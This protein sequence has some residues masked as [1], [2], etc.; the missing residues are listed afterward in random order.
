MIIS[1]SRRTDIPAFYSE[2][3][4]NRIKAGY[5]TVPN[6]FNRNQISKVSLLPKDIDVIVFWTRNPR[7]LLSYLTELDERG[8]RYYFQ[9][10][11]MAN[12][13]SLDIKSPHVD[14]AIDTFIQLSETIGPE[15]VIW[16]YDPI[17]FTTATSVDFHLR[18]YSKIASSLSEHTRRSV[19]S[20]VDEYPKAKR[21]ISAMANQSAKYIPIEQVPKCEFE[22]FIK[23]LV[24]ISQENK[25]EIFSCAEEIDL[26][27]LGV[28]P[29]KCIDDNYINSV[30]GIDVI[31]KKDPSQR[32]VCGCV[33]SKDIGA[34]DT[35]LFGCQY[36]YATSSFERAKRQHAEHNPLSPSIIGYYNIE[37]KTNESTDEQLS[38]WPK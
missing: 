29:G 35:C 26:K 12:P 16:R 14:T 21:R 10:T 18:T 22:N 32:E 38:F 34:Y 13:R 23:N 28:Q 6:P 17:V 3:F 2:W 5:C 31:H 1:A 30:F 11:V 19:I 4:I 25:M 24:F 20:I 8:F 7:P 9:Y 27:S 33:V 36:C 15:K 37:A